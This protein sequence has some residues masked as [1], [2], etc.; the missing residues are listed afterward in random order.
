MPPPIRRALLRPSGLEVAH[1]N[2]QG[3]LLQNM[4]NDI[5]VRKDAEKE[6]GLNLLSLTSMTTLAYCKTSSSFGAPLYSA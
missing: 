5:I 3:I 1:Y 2:D 6:K 4:S